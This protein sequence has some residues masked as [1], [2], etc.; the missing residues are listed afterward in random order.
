M[1]NNRRCD[2]NWCIEYGKVLCPKIIIRKNILVIR[3]GD[4]CGIFRCYLGYLKKNLIYN[5]R[6]LKN[7]FSFIG[8]SEVL[9][10]VY[11][12]KIIVVSNGELS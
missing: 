4:I 5:L 12:F 10:D 9:E 1:E 7:Y 11:E 2:V 8:V 6:V 3:K